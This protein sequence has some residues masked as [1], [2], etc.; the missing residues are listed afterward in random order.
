MTRT[1]TKALAVFVSGGGTNLQALLDRFGCYGRPDPAAAVRLVV[2]DRPGIGA[3]E[4]AR[5]AGVATVVVS[6]DEHRGPGAFARALL[7][8]LRAHAIEIVVL[9]GYVRLVPPEVVAEYRGRMVNIHPGPLPAFGGPGLYGRRVHEAVLK[10]GL[11]VT[12]PTVHFVDERYDHGPIIAHW[13]VPVRRGD[14]AETLA[15]RV[16]E[17]E[18][19]LFPAVVSALARGRIV[20]DE[21]GRVRGSIDEADDTE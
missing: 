4:R 3:V 19:R 15:A 12:G 13:P 18:H 1:A 10:A 7:D 9:A 2:A 17:T 21:A 14:T 20:L 6:P 5:A 16:L 8:A 11:D